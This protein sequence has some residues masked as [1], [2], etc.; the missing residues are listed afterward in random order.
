MKLLSVSNRKTIKG[1]KYGW[2]T[3]ILHLAPATLAGKTVCPFASKGCAA[4]CLNTAGFG[5]YARVQ[6]A[7]I[8]R[9]KLFWKDR[10]T[11]LSILAGE[12]GNLKL[13]AQKRRMRLAIRLNGTSDIAWEGMNI[14]QRFP[15]VQFYDYTKIPVRMMRVLPENYHLTFSRSESNEQQAKLVS[16]LGHNVAIVFADKLP[17]KWWDKKVIDGDQTDLRFLDERGVIVGL[18]AKARARRDTSGFVV[19]PENEG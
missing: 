2:I 1:E 14:I 3:G 11:F 15:D 6:N 16:N 7:R 18:S 10:E 9:T 19:H 4:A 5:R 8:A 12:I 17:K 13:A